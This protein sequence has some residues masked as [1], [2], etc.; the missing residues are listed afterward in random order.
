VSSTPELQV[1]PEVKADRRGTPKRAYCQLD[2]WGF[3]PRYTGGVCPICGWM[4]D[5]VQAAPAW[6]RVLKKLDWEIL[7]LLVLVIALVV[8]GGLVAYAA[9][10][11]PGLKP[12]N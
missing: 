9:G 1:L 11:A 12:H 6:I 7:G 5:G 4:P 10:L 3:D 2:H 8:L